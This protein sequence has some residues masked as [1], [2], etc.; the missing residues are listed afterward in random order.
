MKLEKIEETNKYTLYEK[1]DSGK[2][3]KGFI[4]E[5][6]APWITRKKYNIAWN[7][8]R[9]ASAQ[10]MDVLHERH[11]DAELWAKNII[12]RRYPKVPS[13]IENI[14]NSLDI[15]HLVH[16]TKLK[17]LKS[18]LENGI[19]TRKCLEQYSTE[20]QYNDSLRLDGHLDAISISIAFPNA[21]MLFKYICETPNTSWVILLL[22]TSVLWKYDCAFCKRNAAHKK[23]SGQ[24][25]AE[26]KSPTS[27]LSMF[28]ELPDLESRS[29][30]RLNGYDP[31]DVQAELL[32][33]NTIHQS[34]IKQI[35]FDS[36]ERLQSHRELCGERV[37][38]VH[39]VGNGYFAGRRFVR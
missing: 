23:I 38:S 22:D 1:E 4:V 5:V 34:N 24:E 32:V 16:F 35:I 14:S 37:T 31:T 39:S 19:Q 12:M 28:D 15:P 36:K 30:Q 17:N 9:F 27:F 13:E 29:A 10:D 7:R 6:K 26:L 3:W 2:E 33:F 8:E 11:E 21:K 18:I 25:I 20:Y